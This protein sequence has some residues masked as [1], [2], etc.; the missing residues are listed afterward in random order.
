MV[1]SFI[2]CTC[3]IS[4]LETKVVVPRNKYQGIIAGEDPLLRIAIQI[5]IGVIGGQENGRDADGTPKGVNE[6]RLVLFQK[7]GGP[8][9]WCCGSS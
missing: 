3:L 7:H 5:V 6:K 4:N 1:F 8:P 9:M 2:S